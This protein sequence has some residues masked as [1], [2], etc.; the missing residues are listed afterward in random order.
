MELV[1]P[2]AG[3]GPWERCRPACSCSTILSGLPF[4]GNI[5]GVVLACLEPLKRVEGEAAVTTECDGRDSA[6]AGEPVDLRL[7]HL[8]ALGQLVGGQE[9]VAHSGPPSP[10]G[11]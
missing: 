10:S 8:P 9:S 2:W 5:V 11:A 6:L 7:R 1:P 3:G 4:A